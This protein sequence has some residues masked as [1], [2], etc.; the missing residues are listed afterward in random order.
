M[1]VRA[2]G[3][4]TGRGDARRAQGQT[5]D[6]LRSCVNEPALSRMPSIDV[7]LDTSQQPRSELKLDAN[8]KA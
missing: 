4:C 5:G 2:C 6:L 1:H 8:A 7:T 3:P